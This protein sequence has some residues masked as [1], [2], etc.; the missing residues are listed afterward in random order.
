[1]QFDQFLDQGQVDV[2]VFIGVVVCIVDVME[3][4]EDV[5]LLVQC[6]VG[7]GVGD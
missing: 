4:F 5:C 7:V 2:G 3:M 6:N 1:M